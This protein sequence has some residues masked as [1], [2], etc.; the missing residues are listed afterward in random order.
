[1]PQTV[2]S[3]GSALEQF[4][5]QQTVLEQAVWLLHL[6]LLL[7]QGHAGRP[8]WVLGGQPVNDVP[9]LVEHVVELFHARAA[10]D[11]PCTGL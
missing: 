5:T 10:V 7:G 4:Q 2:L 8:T 11:E 9:G 1:M 3:L 6:S